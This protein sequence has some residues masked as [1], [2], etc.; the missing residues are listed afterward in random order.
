[1]SWN[2]TS[3][4]VAFLAVAV[5]GGARCTAEDKPGPR[6]AGDGL[7]AGEGLG[8][9]QRA[10]LRRYHKLRRL[11]LRL[12]EQKRFR[13]AQDKV[14]RA[15]LLAGQIYGP[16]HPLQ[17]QTIALR[18]RIYTAMDRHDLALDSYRAEV[19]IWRRAL[20]PGSNVVVADCLHR[21]GVTLMRAGK[22]VEARD[23]LVKAVAMK[24]ATLDH[25]PKRL[26]NHYRD[27][28]KPPREPSLAASLRALARVHW[29]LKAQDKA[30][31]L[32]RE[33]L[34]LR[35]KH[36]TLK[37][38]VQSL[39]DLA[40]CHES[41]GRYNL[42]ARL[43]SE[44]VTKVR[45]GGKAAVTGH[46]PA[47]A[48]SLKRLADMTLRAGRTAQAEKH[49]AE[50]RKVALRSAGGGSGPTTVFFAELDSRLGI[51]YARTNRAV[52]AA[53]L[54]RKA[55]AVFHKDVKAN[56]DAVVRCLIQLAKVQ[57]SGKKLGPATKTIRRA[58]DVVRKH[59]GHRTYAYARA[60][61]ELGEVYAA[62][63]AREQAARILGRAFEIVHKLYGSKNPRTRRLRARLVALYTTL[64]WKDKLRDLPK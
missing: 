26:G 63:Q 3:V 64:G 62:R 56:A 25:G 41:L 34:D 44:I 31:A 29:K 21:I 37:D 43:H 51:L 49:Y 27:R 45:A 58:L 8:E 5:G 42:A 16:T 7:E 57:R 23:I 36:P 40:G 35:R 4:V 13:A 14:A 28:T 48:L 61:A 22:A 19:R 55:L 2:R 15:L 11:A 30:V 47:L 52:L 33:A 20:Y 32:F 1:M 24:R 9:E 18:G 10:N 53:S 60:L 50:A 38:L 12:L 39:A 6:R 46:P 54:L 17:A 59:Q